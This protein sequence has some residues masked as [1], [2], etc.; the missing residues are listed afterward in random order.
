MTRTCVDCG[1]QD[2]VTTGGRKIGEKC[3]SCRTRDR[4]KEDGDL[5]PR[6]AQRIRVCVDC[7]DRREVSSAAYAKV[8]RCNP[9]SKR[10][11]WREG[12]LQGKLLPGTALSDHSTLDDIDEVVV[13]RM[14]AG[15]KVADPLWAERMAAYD[16]LSR[17]GYGPG[18]IA[19]KLHVSGATLRR[20]ARDLREGAQ[21][22]SK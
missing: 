14:V 5:G 1:A 15:I 9:C 6:R 20:I 4:W 17:R 8:L 22:Q 18:Q 2:V 16:T 11:R 7:G 10:A 13:D 12:D 21:C 19:E 3:R